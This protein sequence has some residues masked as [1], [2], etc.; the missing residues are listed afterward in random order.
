AN[1]KLGMWVTGTWM[2]SAL[3]SAEFTWDVQIEP[4]INQHASHFFSN[5]VA[6]SAT[7]A[8]AEAAQKLALFLTSSETAANVRVEHNWELPALNQPEY[9]ESFLSAEPPAN[10]AAVFQALES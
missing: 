6:V 7:T 2:F 9:L 4:M 1:G 10:R 5:A 3:D 8:H